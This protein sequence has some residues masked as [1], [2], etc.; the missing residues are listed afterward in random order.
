M[1]NAAENQT[2]P[3]FGEKAHETLG[4]EFLSPETI[5]Q[6]RRNAAERSQRLALAEIEEMSRENRWQDILAAFFPLQEKLP[7]LADEGLDSAVRERIA[8]ALGQ[9][10]RFDEAIA[11]LQICVGRDPENFHAHSSLAYT[12]Y[13][14]LYA[15]KNRQIL[16]AGRHRAERIRLAHQH[17]QAAQALRPDGVTVFYREGMLWKQIEG[18]ADKALPLFQK[19]VANW[20]SLAD[21]ERERRHQERKNYVKALYQLA[22]T[23]CAVERPKAALP[24]LKKCIAEDEQSGHLSLLHKHFAL[25]KVYFLLNRLEE[26]RD[27]LQFALRC[28]TEGPVDFVHELLGRVFLGLN[29]PAKAL[30]AVRQVPEKARRPYV[31]WTEADALCSLKRWSEAREVLRR[32][33]ERDG[34]SRHKTLIRLCQIEYLLGETSKAFGHAAEADRFFREQWG[35]PSA[36]ALF[37]MA[38]C[39]LKS[40]DRD[41]ARSLAEELQA[42]RPGY[43]KLDLLLSKTQGSS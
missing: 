42:Y 27:A 30:E 12:A 2:A 6:A 10:G 1:T 41:K 9:L 3:D 26:A 34:R 13:N 25:G 17:F 39:A 24:V 40:G 5:V 28:R 38:A 18:K 16:L 43:E 15:A 32:A 11:E 36:D 37:W 21:E 33:L 8:F 7:E 23:L 31:R 20:E 22:S 14:S 29:E 19:A 4:D 35:N